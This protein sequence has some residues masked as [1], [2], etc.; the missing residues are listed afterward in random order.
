MS[1]HDTEDY[2]KR[3]VFKGYQTITLGVATVSS[4]NNLTSIHNCLIPGKD[5]SAAAL[6]SMDEIFRSVRFCLDTLTDDE[7]EQL[8]LGGRL[9]KRKAHLER[10]TRYGYDYYTAFIRKGLKGLKKEAIPSYLKTNVCICKHNERMRDARPEGRKQFNYS[11]E[12]KTE[13]EIE[14]EHILKNQ[15]YLGKCARSR[16]VMM[17]PEN[18]GQL[19]TL[20]RA[21]DAHYKELSRDIRVQNVMRVLSLSGKVEESAAPKPKEEELAEAEEEELAEPGE[22]ERAELEE[23]EQAEPEEEERAEPGEEEQAEP[24]EEER[25]EP[26]EE[27]RAEPEEEERAEPGEEERAEPEEEER[28]EPGE[29]ERAE[30][31]EEESDVDEEPTS[32]A[33]MEP[34]SMSGKNIS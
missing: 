10:A 22:E 21:L 31:E 1:C 18:E 34:A 2:Y 27:E 9:M 7:K 4:I 17:N 33:E 29:E 8:K 25:A 5:C 28:A 6:K 11:V 23:E 14:G 3:V 15:L 19:I 13:G 24:E 32:P 16:I 12:I 30:P 20:Q 26:E